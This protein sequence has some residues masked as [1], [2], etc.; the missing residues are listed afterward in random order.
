MIEV[1]ADAVAAQRVHIAA[2]TMIE[3]VAIAP[4]IDQAIRLVQPAL[5]ARAIAV[6]RDYEPFADAVIDRY[7][8]LRVLRSLMA[9]AAEYRFSSTATLS[10]DSTLLSR[11]TSVHALVRLVFGN[12]GDSGE[13]VA[14]RAVIE[15]ESRDAH[16]RPFFRI[17]A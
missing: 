10:G 14:T 11:T 12:L 7:K 9:N 15:D 2:Q 4:V 3:R 17:S 8:L 16:W 6:V 5:D 1:V 13:R